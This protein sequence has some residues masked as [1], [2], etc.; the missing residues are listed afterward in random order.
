MELLSVIFLRSYKGSILGA[1]WRE[2]K[3][4]DTEQFLKFGIQGKNEKTENTQQ[5]GGAAIWHWLL[6]FVGLK[7]KYI[8]DHKKSMVEGG[9]M[10]GSHYWLQLKKHGTLSSRKSRAQ[11]TESMPIFEIKDK[12]I[13]NIEILRKIWLINLFRT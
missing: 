1:L 9:A 7:E 10:V 5:R 13:S 3:R 2:G 6:Y 12:K 11:S 4:K 8:A